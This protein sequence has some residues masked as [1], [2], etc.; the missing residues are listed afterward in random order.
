[1]WGGAAAAILDLD[2]R[3]AFPSL[4]W[5]AVRAAVDEWAPELPRWTSWCHQGAVGIQLPSGDWVECDRGAE[6]GDPL[7]PV[8][9][10]LTLLRCADAGRRAVE[11]RG[12]W[13]WDAWYMDDGQVVLPPEF[14]ATYLEA[15][16]AALRAAGGTRIA[17][18]E[19][20]SIARLLGSPEACARVPPTWCRGVVQATCKLQPPGPTGKMLGVRIAGDD[21]GAQ[22]SSAAEATAEAC[23]ALSLLEDAPA[24]LALLR[25]ST[26]ACRVMHLLRAAGPEI[27]AAALVDFDERQ[28]HALAS[29]LGGPLSPVALERA[30]CGAADGGLGLRRTAEVCLPAFLASRTEA[31]ALAEEVC[32]AL[33]P[34]WRGALLAQWDASTA[35]AAQAWLT[36]LPP[37]TRGLAQQV[38]A[39]GAVEAQRVAAELVGRA[40]C[41]LARDF[42]KSAHEGIIAPSGLEDPEHPDAAERGGLQTRL[43]D[44]AA[45][46]RLD[47]IYAELQT[48]GDWSGVR[49]LDDLRDPGTDHPW[50]RVLCSATDKIAT[51][52]EGCWCHEHHL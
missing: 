38:L 17:G 25:M 31:R 13:V 47:A 45:G 24:E 41:R 50:M 21:L 8:Y 32:G 15:F 29:V 48:Q 16:D 7:G 10:A 36:Q 20:K 30:A 3:N 18:E 2:L 27:P 19:F 6:Q 37:S 4:E 49:L 46:V 26:N 28:E 5:P 51:R 33:P 43:C 40:P 44:L 34:S 11:A 35:A 1:M 14:A 12:G 52:L 9:C 22:F 42:A 23:G 39:E